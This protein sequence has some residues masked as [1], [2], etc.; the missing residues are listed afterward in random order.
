MTREK[1]NIILSILTK[2]NS[3]IL[4]GVAILFI[5]L[6]NFLHLTMFHFPEENEMSFSVDKAKAFFDSLTGLSGIVNDFFSHLGWIGVPVFIFLTGYGI[7]LRT[8]PTGGRNVVGFIKRNYIKLFAL[9]LPAILF[10]AAGDVLRGDIWPNLMKRATYLTMLANFVYPYVYSLPGVYW[11]F[12]FT[13]QFYLLWALFGQ[14][15]N[16]KNLLIW[17]VVFLIGLFFLASYG[18]EDALSIYRHCFTGWFP[19]FAVGIWMGSRCRSTIENPMKSSV[20]MELSLFVLLL[21]LILLMSKWLVS[22]L[23]IP[24]VALVW[25]IVIGLLLLRTR[26]ISTAFRWIG[27]YAACLFVCHPIARSVVLALVYP[28]IPNLAANVVIYIFLSI[29]IAVVYSSIY[30]WLLSKMQLKSH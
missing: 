25:F 24:L 12:G 19:V 14:R 8:P 29:V 17:S 30:R 5:V 21:G 3:L 15:F 28:R 18:P 7:A 16:G 10:F 1:N 23:F 26:Y 13:F 22:W 4:R 6:H 11:Y 2:E 9:M 27:K 20:W